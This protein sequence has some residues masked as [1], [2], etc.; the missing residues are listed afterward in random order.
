M[1]LTVFLNYEVGHIV[2]K[3]TGLQLSVSIAWKAPKKEVYAVRFEP[4]HFVRPMN[5]L[6]LA[7]CFGMEVISHVI[8][9]IF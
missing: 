3:N 2:G 9:I 4:V 1:N 6:A 8:C 5:L 7:T